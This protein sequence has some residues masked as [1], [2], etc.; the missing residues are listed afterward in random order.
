V[1]KAKK[2]PIS[3]EV[4]AHPLGGMREADLQYIYRSHLKGT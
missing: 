2:N 1:E 3:F 4:G